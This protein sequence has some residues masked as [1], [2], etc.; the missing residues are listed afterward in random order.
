[1]FRKLQKR[2]TKQQIKNR[3]MWYYMLLKKFLKRYIRPT[4]EIKIL[5][6]QQ[7][8]SRKRV[9]TYT[10]LLKPYPN[11]QVN[12]IN[13][14][15]N[16]FQTWHTKNLP[17]LMHYAVQQVKIFNPRFTHYLFDDNDCREFIKNNYSDD[18]LNAYDTL[19]PGAF[20]ADL[21]RYCILYKM[22]GIYLDIKYKPINGFKFINLLD[23]DHFVYDVNNIDIYNALMICSPGNEILL[24]A[25]NKIVDNVK[26]KFYGSSFLEPTGP[27]LLTNIISDK[28]Y[29]DLKHKELNGNSDYKIIY[30]NEYPILKSYDGHHQERDKYC[31]KEHYA[32]LWKNKKIYV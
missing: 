21:W 1:M 12:N 13:I 4:Q 29:I 19:I 27:K 25:I 26:H 11:S 24:N 14:P 18:V 17:P 30:H 28:S 6:Q 2:N 5:T 7:P 16:I 23:R 20:K 9:N 22:G 10:E 3:N 8:Q 31:I 32:I 15:Q